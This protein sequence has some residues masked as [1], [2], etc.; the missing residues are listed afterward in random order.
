MMGEIS[1]ETYNNNNNNWHKVNNAPKGKAIYCKL[2][3][4]DY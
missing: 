4:E 3:C 1:P 2:L